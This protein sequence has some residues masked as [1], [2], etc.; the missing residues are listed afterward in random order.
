MT[1]FHYPSTRVVETGLNSEIVQYSLTAICSML[2]SELLLSMVVGCSWMI[3]E[4]DGND[5]LKVVRILIQ[6]MCTKVPDRAEYR[7]K[8]SQVSGYCSSVC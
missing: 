1:G 5:T 4:I 2:S 6:N 8:I 3:R 7:A